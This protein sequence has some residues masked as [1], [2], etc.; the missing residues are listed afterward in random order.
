MNL[1]EISG[2]LHVFQP[3]NITSTAL[4]FLIETIKVLNTPRHL[5]LQADFLHFLTQDGTDAV[6][7]R[8]P[9][10]AF[11]LYFAAHPLIFL[12]FQNL[13]SLTFYPLF[14]PDHPRPSAK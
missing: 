6:Y 5:G 13:N 10:D 12:R 8:A 11:S 9:L 14:P 3:V 2:C 1:V 7:V 4:E